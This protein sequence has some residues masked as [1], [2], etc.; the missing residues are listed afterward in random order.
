MMP[1]VAPLVSQIIVRKITD[2]NR[3]STIFLTD[4]LQQLVSERFEESNRL[5]EKDFGGIILQ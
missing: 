2:K 1:K 4:E 5:L 3:E